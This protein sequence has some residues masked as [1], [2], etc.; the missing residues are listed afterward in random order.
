[1]DNTSL[2]EIRTGEWTGS[3]SNHIKVYCIK[4]SGPVSIKPD[5]ARL[6]VSLCASSP[7]LFF[8]DKGRCVCFYR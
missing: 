6:K 3:D 4:N 2:R 8:I 7:L 1:V 5:A